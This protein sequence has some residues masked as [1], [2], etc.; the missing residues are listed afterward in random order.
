[1]QAPSGVCLP[2]LRNG[3]DKHLLR[4]GPCTEHTTRKEEM[5]NSLP[6]QEDNQPILGAEGRQGGGLETKRSLLFAPAKFIW[7]GAMKLPLN[8]RLSSDPLGQP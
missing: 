6:W 5:G 1:M 7:G 2:L 3:T 4:A 8:M